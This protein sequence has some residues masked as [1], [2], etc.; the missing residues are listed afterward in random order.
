MDQE[1]TDNMID[2]DHYYEFSEDNVNHP[3]HYNKHPSGIEAI[4]IIRWHNF[5]VGCCLK[6]LWRLGLKDGENDIKDLEKVIWYAYDEIKRLR[7][8]ERRD[9][10]K[11][12]K[13][14]DAILEVK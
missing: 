2:K 3:T 6:Y 8:I 9:T 5:N 12:D 11:E 13:I 4:E 7:E 14:V 1:I 10:T